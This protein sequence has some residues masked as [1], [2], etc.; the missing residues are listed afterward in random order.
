M[1]THGVDDAT[2]P[3]LPNDPVGAYRYDVRTEVWT[4]TPEVYAMH[5]VDPA[6]TPTSELLEQHRHPED[7]ES[8]VGLVRSLGAG[9][10]RFS[11]LH[12]VVR[13]DGDVREL[14]AVGEADAAPDGTVAAVAGFYVDL[15]EGL[16]K[17]LSHAADAAVR[18]AVEHRA[19]IEQAKGVLSLAYG[20]TDE[21]AISLL[22]AVSSRRNIRLSLLA[23][24]LCAAVRDG[25]AST[26]ALRRRMDDVLSAVSRADDRPG[27]TA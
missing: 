20:L 13:A 19:A 16:T 12:R 25:A 21:E 15:S 24:R 9:G 23:E 2:S 22:R 7:P 17:R 26:Q 4:W 11:L 27:T 8:V 18:A 14:V 10:E 3:C 6:L 1:T 5:G